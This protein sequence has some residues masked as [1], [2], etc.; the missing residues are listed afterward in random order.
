MQDLKILFALNWPWWLVLLVTMLGLVTVTL[1]YRRAAGT[2]SR[3]YLAVLMVLRGV[4]MLALFLCLFRPVISYQKGTIERSRLLILVDRSRSMSIHDFP[5]QPSRFDRV[6]D[7]LLERN[8]TVG[9][10]EES[11]DLNWYAFADHAGP[12]KEKAELGSLKAE[13]DATDLFTSAKDA[14]ADAAGEEIGGIIMLTDGRDTSGRQLARM[15]GFNLPVFTVGVGSVLRA[16]ENF[17]DIMIDSIDAKREVTVKIATPLTVMVEAI[18]F[19]DRVVPVILKENDVE[20]GRERLVLDNAKGAQKVTLNYVPQ[21]KG[22]FEL[23]ISIPADA[24]ERITEN[25]SATIP[26]FVG[27]PKIRVL[28]IEGVARPEY[29]DLK[30]VL[31]YDPNVEIMSFVRLGPNF[32]IKQGTISDVK[33]NDPPKKYEDLKQFKVLIIGSIES[34]F[35]KDGQMQ[36]IRRF[37]RE[38]GGLLMIGGQHAFGPG[39]YSGTPIE[40]ALP[41]VCGGRNAGQEREAFSLQ[42]TGAGKRHPIFAGIAKFFEPG[43]KDGVTIPPLLGC[44]RVEKAKPAA[45]VLAVNPNRR[46]AAGPLIAVATGRYGSGRSMAATIDSTRLWYVPLKGMGKASPY[47]RYWGQAIRWLAGSDDAR[48]ATGPGVTAY[49]DRHFYDPGSEPVIHAFVTDSEGQAT[50][51]A[52]VEATITR[53]GE[54][55]SSRV[56]LSLVQGTRNEY[57]TQLLPPDPGK[58]VVEVKGALNDAALGEATLVFFIGEPTREF[59]KLDLNADALAKVA[60][61]TGGLYLPLLS[62]D[63]LPE[64]LKA[65]SEEK[66]ERHE[67][68]LWNTPIL[69]IAFLLFVTSEWILRKRRLLS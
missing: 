37:V 38:G 29:N 57:E 25:N 14:A 16:Q 34:S 51:K 13:G 59:E 3:R 6:R 43:G 11:F 7:I 2:I 52:K 21:K 30:N 49:T 45:E 23:T 48:R 28:Y 56:Q 18:G 69:F 62:F 35:F 47:V 22:D 66:V 32:F 1:F 53:E 67:I 27:D 9:K 65:R 60:T 58:Y 31:Q 5:G 17:R 26:V 46:N 24:G 33:L 54:K 50:A 41:V 40:E 36:F 4:A 19:P 42:L 8:G 55:K 15:G 20:I 68:F 10:L 44:T 12:L 64:V 39:G 61:A 63:Q